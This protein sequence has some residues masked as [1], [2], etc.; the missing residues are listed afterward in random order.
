M[1]EFGI[2]GEPVAEPPVVAPIESD[3]RQTPVREE[4]MEPE[5]G[6]ELL[7]PEL[8]PRP[9][10]VLKKPEPPTSRPKLTINKR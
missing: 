4:L 6:P 3:P 2:G 5:L 9:K 10:L 1:S 8:E 7:E